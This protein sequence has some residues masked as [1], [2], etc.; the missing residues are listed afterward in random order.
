[1]VSAAKIRLEGVIQGVG[2]RPFIFRLCRESSL[3][4]FILNTS[5]GVEIHVEASREAII[6]FYENLEENLPPLAKVTQKEITF[7]KPAGYNDFSIKESLKT[8]ERSALISPDIATCPDCL[9]ELFDPQDR[10]FLYPFINCTNCG[11]RFSIIEGLPYD[12]PLTTMSSF[13][14]CPAC[15]TEYKD[16]RQRRFHAQPNACP[17]CGPV[18][19]LV[20]LSG[21]KTRSLARGEKALRET[22]RLLKSG[23]IIAIKGIGG[24]HISCDADNPEAVRAL[25]ERKKRPYK[26]F[27]VMVKD[28]PGLSGLCEVSA[29]EKE[30]LCS[31]ESP[32]VLL[33]KTADNNITRQLSPYNNYLGVMLAYAPLHHLLLSNEISAAKPLKKLVMTSANITDDPIEIDNTRAIN[34]L[35]GICD[36]FL[37]H[38]RRIHNRADDSIVQIMDGRPV[39]LRRGRGYSPFPFFTDSRMK[40]I[41]ACGAELKNTFCLAKDNLAFLSQFIG[42]LKTYP[43]FTFYQETIGRLCGLL[44]I[45]PAMIACDLHPDYL[46]TKYALQYKENRPAVELVGVQHHHAHLASVICEHRIKGKIIGV[47]FDGIG[48]GTDGKIWGGEFFTGDLGGF[49]RRGHLE[50]TPMPGGDKATREPFRMG[51]S[52]LYKTFGPDLSGIK[53]PFTAKYRKDL[54]RIIN[55]AQINPL[56]TSSCG[57]LFDGVSALAGICDIITFEAEAAI[58]LQ[59]LAE[60]SRSDKSYDFSIRDQSG[61]FIIKPQPAIHQLVEDIK[62]KTDKK[63]IARKFHNGLAKA[64]AQACGIIR[65]KSNIET[66]VLS[67]G[68]FQNRLFMETCLKHLRGDKFTVYYNQLLPANDGA[69]SLGQAALANAREK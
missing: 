44:G 34:N 26:P 7:V 61:V 66:V 3:T 19:E 53:I 43:S 40:N 11:P 29:L 6:S 32:I 17:E 20:S 27:A 33:R 12:R 60:G 54:D 55:S 4:G 5:S 9:K 58:R 10:R 37:V 16:V 62:N 49:Q 52:Y 22:V 39:L 47:C 36:Y 30:I 46:S 41:L 57:R 18:L 14:M 48:Y 69:V 65:G 56:L 13:K 51:I 38:N 2:F 63:D 21:R 28:I 31:P 64:A 42:D 68:V 24:F 45:K 25:R 67:G 59:I 35:G 8:R 15:K 50:Y 1:M 23:K